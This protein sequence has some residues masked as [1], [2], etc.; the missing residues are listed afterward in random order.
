M[1]VQTFDEATSESVCERAVPAISDPG[2]ETDDIY[3]DA[4]IDWDELDR[5]RFV[6]LVSQCRRP[7]LVI[8]LC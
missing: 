8:A 4:A 3:L 2:A 1:T 7:P 6:S 5:E